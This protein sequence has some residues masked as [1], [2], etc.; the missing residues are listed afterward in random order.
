MP[1]PVSVI[2]EPKDTRWGDLGRG[3]GS[4]GGLGIGL[5]LRKKLRE[6]EKKHELALVKAK[7]LAKRTPEQALIDQFITSKNIALTSK[8]PDEKLTAAKRLGQLEKI[9]SDLQD[10]KAKKVGAEVGAE[11][12]AKGEQKGTLGD[13]AGE[14]EGKRV[15]A[16]EE[17]LISSKKKNQTFLQ[18]FQE[19]MAKSQALGAGRGAEAVRAETVPGRLAEM[20]ERIRTEVRA[21]AETQRDMLP[22]T[23]EMER[24][25][26]KA[27]REPL[28]KAAARAGLIEASRLRQQLR[29][30]PDIAKATAAARLSNEKELI[31]YRF[32]QQEVRD[33]YQ[34][35]WDRQDMYA[36]IQARAQQSQLDSQIK[37]VQAEIKEMDELTRRKPSPQDKDWAILEK[38]FNERRRANRMFGT[39]LLPDSGYGADYLQ[40]VMSEP[41]FD[42]RLHLGR[43]K[44]NR[45]KPP[46]GWSYTEPEL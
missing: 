11:I 27:R 32:E 23:V 29:Y 22:A 33:R 20:D 14:I 4:I 44:M 40:E 42:L 28:T 7:A 30:A 15:T 24:Q 17:A 12:E 26:S 37:I 2:Y 6:G 39:K 43:D 31:A 25:I 38:K 5:K 45:P 35:A 36:Q 3:A 21:Q 9:F 18:K 8:D 19:G 46:S 41:Q 34:K 13:I 1:T 16:Q 10:L